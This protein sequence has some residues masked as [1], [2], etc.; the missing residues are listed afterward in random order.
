MRRIVRLLIA[1]LSLLILFGVVLG[2]AG[3]WVFALDI[4]A[5]FRPHLLWL[6]VPVAFIAFILRRWQAVWRTVVA[7]VLAIGGLA[8]MWEGAAVPG[9]GRAV[10]VMTANVYQLNPVPEAMRLALIRAD[11]DILVTNETVKSAINGPHALTGTYPY[12]LSLSTSGQTLRTVIWSR[13][14]MRD[15]ALLLEDQLTP[16]GARAIVEIA[17]ELELAVLAVHFNHPVY[18]NQ[19][20]QIEAL[21]VIAEALPTPRVILGDF[22]ATPWSHAIRRAEA[23]TGT[24]R[25]PGH[26]IT[27]QG[28]YPA[29][30]LAVPEPIG[31]AIDHILLSPGI[32]V[33]AVETIMI[34]GS[35]HVAVK[36]RIQIPQG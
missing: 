15:G 17:P 24:R 21:D 13:Y 33:E 23:L 26:R 25:I 16:T 36:A 5:H 30:I 2:F 35:D 1:A 12:R 19:R 32:G 18:G 8:P 6:C 20:R 11:A 31:H 34:P 9:T 28:R 14:P 29:E 7:A 10:T 27:W 4:L 22:N 3:P